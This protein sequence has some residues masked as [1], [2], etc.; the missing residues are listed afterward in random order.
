VAH[1]E[2]NLRSFAA[3]LG[4][5]LAIQAYRERKVLF[6]DGAIIALCITVTCRRRKHK[7]FGQAQSFVPGAP[8]NIQ[9]RSEPPFDRQKCD[10]QRPTR[11]RR[12][13]LPATSA[14]AP[15]A[16]LPREGWLPAVRPQ[17]SPYTVAY[18]VDGQLFR[19]SR[20]LYLVKTDDGART[21]PDMSCCGTESSGPRVRCRQARAPA[22]T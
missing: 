8:T 5:D 19:P 16:A 4:N 10:T 21:I 11:R 3:V 20:S 9:F 1:E 12:T 6:P 17:S 13:P 18:V 14:V 22:R 15:A 7:V 2:G